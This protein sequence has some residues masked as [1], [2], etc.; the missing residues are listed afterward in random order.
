MA[1]Q[2]EN[3]ETWSTPKSE[4]G[5]NLYWLKDGKWGVN[6][7]FVELNSD[8]DAHAGL[9]WVGAQTSRSLDSYDELFKKVKSASEKGQ[10][11]AGSKLAEV[12]VGYGHASVADMAPIMLFFNQLPMH[13]A[14]RVFSDISTGAGQELSTRYVDITDFGL[15]ELSTLVND[16]KTPTGLKKKYDALLKDMGSTYSQWFET[17]SNCLS[18]YLSKRFEGD[19]KQSTITSRTLDV[20]RMFIPFGTRTSQAFLG[21]VRNWVD[22][23]SQLRSSGDPQALAHAEHILALLS[24][25]QH[26]DYSGEIHAELSALTRHSEGS[27]RTNKAQKKIRDY[28]SETDTD[29]IIADYDDESIGSSASRVRLLNDPRYRYDGQDLIT[30]YML[31]EY[32]NVPLHRIQDYVAGLDDKQLE[33]LGNFIFEGHTHHDLMRNPADVRGTG[34]VYESALA[35]HRDANRQRALGRAATILTSDDVFGTLSRGWN[36]NY[37]MKEADYWSPYRNAW[38]KDMARIYEKIEEIL[39]DVTEMY[40]IE[41]AHSVMLNILPLGHQTTMVVSGPPSQWNYATSLRIGLGGDFGYRDDFWNMLE[42][43]RHSDPVYRSMSGHLV[44]PDVND[45]VQIVGR[46]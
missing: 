32:P 25:D 6:G 4:A 27:D 31:C 7:S 29:L 11:S 19:V 8:F 35:F 5:L 28:V 21:S 16:A 46:S 37:A 9:A 44:K 17:L 14:Y 30:S 39:V 3:Y 34:I 10:R 33:I 22:L 36:D 15:P 24:L 20:T 42:L 18:D 41:K 2:F 43:I 26:P 13:I 45:P 40:G 38:H 12:F 1:V 23:A